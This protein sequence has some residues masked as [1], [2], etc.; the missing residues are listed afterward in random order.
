MLQFCPCQHGTVS[1]LG[2]GPA[3][4]LA[5]SSHLTCVRQKDHY[6]DVLAMVN[7]DMEFPV[8]NEQ[9]QIHTRYLPTLQPNR[10]HDEPLY[11]QI[12]KNAVTKRDKQ[13]PQAILHA[14][15]A[16]NNLDYLVVLLAIGTSHRRVF[17][18]SALI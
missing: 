14:M 8:R 2:S 18:I 7:P 3:A 9:N 17:S 15:K 12:I 11:G 16:I 5:C 1:Q 10:N 4:Q 13:K 6:S